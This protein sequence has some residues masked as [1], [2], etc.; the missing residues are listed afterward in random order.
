MFLLASKFEAFCFQI[1]CSKTRKSA[2]QRKMFIS[3]VDVCMDKLLLILMIG[4]F[5]LNISFP[6]LLKTGEKI[7]CRLHGGQFS[8]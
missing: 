1:F 3:V 6:F 5:S 4:T 8:S 7:Y 2:D